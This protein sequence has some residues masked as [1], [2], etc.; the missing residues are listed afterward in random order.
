MTD[1][2]VRITITVV[3]GI[4]AVLLTAFLTYAVT[5]PMPCPGQSKLSFRAKDDWDV[6]DKLESPALGVDVLRTV[7]SQRCY[8]I[9]R[10]LGAQQTMPGHGVALTVIPDKLNADMVEHLAGHE[11]LDF[12]TGLAVYAVSA[13]QTAESRRKREDAATTAASSSGSTADN[14]PNH[15][16]GVLPNECQNNVLIFCPD[17]V[18]E[19]CTSGPGYPGFGGVYDVTT[20]CIEPTKFSTK[21]VTRCKENEETKHDRVIKCLD[22]IYHKAAVALINLQNHP[23]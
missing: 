5:R 1:S 22:K 3:G 4:S 6:H 17:T 12:C 20:K 7:V 13:L 23:Q 18:Q 9:Q 16:V 10:Y 15:V 8:I 21:I 19:H 2:S 11:A 14:H